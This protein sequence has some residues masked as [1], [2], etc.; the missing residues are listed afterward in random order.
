[1][2]RME[3]IRKLFP[4]KATGYGSAVNGGELLFTALATCFCNDLYRE[5]TKRKIEIRA[6]EVTVT[7]N[8]GN[9][10]EPAWDISYYADVQSDLSK[11]ELVEF[12]AYVDRVS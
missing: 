7:E 5:A 1:L 2:R 3:T 8:F 11:D 12:I 9:E 4:A 10:G 6:V